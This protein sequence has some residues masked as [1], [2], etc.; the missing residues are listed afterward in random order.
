MSSSSTS[1]FELIKGCLVILP[2]SAHSQYIHS[3]QWSLNPTC[4]TDACLLSDMNLLQDLSQGSVAPGK[5]EALVEQQKKDI[6]HA[7]TCEC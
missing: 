6:N 1:R 2:Q 5:L 4:D 3:S 7:L